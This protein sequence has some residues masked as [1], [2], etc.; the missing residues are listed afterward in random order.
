[1]ELRKMSRKPIEVSLEALVKD[2]DENSETLTVSGMLIG[3]QDVGFV[4]TIW[5]DKELTDRQK[6]IL[7]LL[8]EGVVQADIAR[9]IGISQTT[10]SKEVAKIR[11]IAQKIHLRG[12]LMEDQY[13]EVYFDQYCKKCLHKDEDETSDA[14]DEC[15]ANPSNINSHKPVNFKEK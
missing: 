3:E 9:E 14:C 12:D 2:T 13:K 6:R 7:G 11:N 5:V 1:M 8:Y 4:D 15:L 10:V